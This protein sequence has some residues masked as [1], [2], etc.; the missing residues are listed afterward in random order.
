MNIL[1]NCYQ[2]LDGDYI[3]DICCIP[4]SLYRIL[5][6]I[7]LENIKFLSLQYQFSQFYNREK[8]KLS[9]EKVFC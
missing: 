5:Y 4:L 3:T 1:L 7:Y 9:S 6:L 2:F 8:A